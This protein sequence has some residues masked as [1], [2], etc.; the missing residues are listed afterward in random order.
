[1]EIIQEPDTRLKGLGK[2][3]QILKYAM[4]DLRKKFELL[5]RFEELGK[6]SKA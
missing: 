3:F 1:L 2:I 6:I 5:T 4:K